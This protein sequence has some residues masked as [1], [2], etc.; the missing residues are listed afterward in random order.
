MVAFSQLKWSFFLY[1]YQV[2][3]NWYPTSRKALP[4]FVSTSRIPY[5]WKI[6]S[7][8]HFINII[9]VL[10]IPRTETFTKFLLFLLY[11]LLEGQ[12]D[13]YKYAGTRDE[14]FR[15]LHWPPIYDA[16]YFEGHCGQPILGKVV[17]IVVDFCVSPGIGESLTNLVQPDPRALQSLT[18][19]V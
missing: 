2:N 4:S 10:L 12:S 18:L 3:T 9:A 14:S 19:F 7:P 15:G 16:Y 13:K 8:R 6:L 17:V 1:G 11:H 5:T